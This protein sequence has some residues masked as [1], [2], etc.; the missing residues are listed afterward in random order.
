MQNVNPTCSFQSCHSVISIYFHKR[1]AFMNHK[2]F[3]FFLKE[4]SAHNGSKSH[5]KSANSSLCKIIIS[6]GLISIFLFAI[7]L[8]AAPIPQKAIDNINKIESIPITT[9]ID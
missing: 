1:I 4:Q 7:L 2:P 8:T 5:E 6:N 9:V 3:I